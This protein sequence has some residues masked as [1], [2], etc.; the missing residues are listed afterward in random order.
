[1]AEK[2][3]DHITRLLALLGYLADHDDVAVVEL[4]EQFG[5]SE[6]QILKDIDL[7]WVTGTPGY[8]PDDLI[9]FSWDESGSRVYLREARGLDRKIRLAPRE[10]LALAVAVQWMQDLAENESL[11]AL[12][13]L[14]AKLAALVPAVVETAPVPRVRT[15]LS[16]AIASQTGVAIE[17]VSAEDERTDRVILPALISTDGAAWYVEGWCALAGAR[18]TFRLD[19]ILSLRPASPDET[20][21]AMESRAHGRRGSDETRLVTFV[22]D[23][24]ARYEAEDLPGAT[25]SESSRGPEVTVHVAR[26]DWLVRLALGG[27]VRSI[28]SDIAAEVRLRAKAAMAAYTAYD[29]GKLGGEST[30]SE[31]S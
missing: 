29:A 3:V 1:M 5:V 23:P 7:L 21:R 16:E 27:A 28:D 11:A 18:R 12:E 9:D 17:Y 25:V 24:A 22:V 31:P 6:A 20:A 19:R 14:S 26:T 13:S 30:G 8:F 15:A 4:A 2:T 10:A